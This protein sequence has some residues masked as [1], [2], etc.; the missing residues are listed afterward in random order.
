M[1]EI[2]LRL[3]VVIFPR[4]YTEAVVTAEYFMKK[5]SFQYILSWEHFIFLSDST[6]FII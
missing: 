1:T 5:K 2:N 3:Y 6:P 4:N